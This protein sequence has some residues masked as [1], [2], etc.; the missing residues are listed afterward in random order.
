MFDTTRLLAWPAAIALLV[1]AAC[2]G[3]SSAAPGPAVSTSGPPVRAT[4]TIV[5]IQGND[6]W[7]M[8]ADSTHQLRLTHEKDQNFANTPAFS[9]DGSLIAYVLHIAPSGNSWGGAELR[10]MKADGSDDRTLVPAKG[11]GE[12]SENP[13]WSAD[14]KSVYYG[15]D[16]PIFDG[17]KY[18]GD[19]LSM[20]GVELATGATRTVVKNAIYPTTSRSGALAWVLFDP[21]TAAFRLQV[22]SSDGSN[23]RT[24]LSNKDFQAVYSPRLSP[25]GHSLIFSGSGRT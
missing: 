5:Y 1:L 19:T 15:H 18:T 25:D 14:G 11:Q 16:L 24:I 9:P 3:R 6:L 20:D 21:T 10:V 2:G 12:R 4:G 17:G 8:S 7:T 22:G 13:A 23:G